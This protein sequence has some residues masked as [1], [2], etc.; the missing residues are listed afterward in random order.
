MYHEKISTAVL[1]HNIILVSKEWHQLNSHLGIMIDCGSGFEQAHQ[2]GLAHLIEHCIFKG[3]PKR[4]SYHIIN[5]L[6]A[7]GG[8]LNAYTSKEETC[9]HASFRN[10]YYDRAAD[11]L[12]D[13]T[14]NSLFPQ[15]EIE[16]EKSVIYEEINSYQDSPA[17]QVMDDY[18]E[19]FYGKHPLAHP[20]L[21]TKDSIANYTT[22]DLQDFVQ[23][24]YNSANV[25]IVSVSPLPMAQQ[26]IILNKYLEQCSI[27]QAT[28]KPKLSKPSYTPKNVTVAKD[29]SQLHCILGVPAYAHKQ[30]ERLA[31]MLLN[32]IIGGPAMNA[33]LNMHIREK[34]AWVYDIS[35]NYTSYKNSGQFSIYYGCDEANHDKVNNAVWKILNSFTTTKLSELKL[36]E[37]KNQLSGQISLGLDS[38]ISNLFGIGKSQLMNNRVITVNES[39]LEIDKITASDLMHVANQI[40]NQHNFTQLVFTPT[41][42]GNND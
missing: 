10:E 31:F 42:N 20:I 26:V 12:I 9:Y 36:R 41:Q 32:N 3:T 35:S 11:L 4:K 14:F 23:Q 25:I 15:A 34:N 27:P 37:A 19:L 2:H 8:E 1:H 29:I 40:F 24:H 7:V 28:A 38:G 33:A 39:L 5:R 17:E 13:I 22:N 18:D 6:D 21:G 30:K 16:K